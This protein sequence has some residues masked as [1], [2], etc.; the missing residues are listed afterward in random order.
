MSELKDI[1][2]S[3]HLTQQEVAKT[4]GISLRSYVSYE[5]DP[6]K[7]STPKYRFLL[8]E[9]SQMNLLDEEHGTLSV[10]EIR[11]VCSDIFQKYPVEFCY[12]FG[13]YAKGQEKESSDVDLLIS[14]T[15]TGLKF[16]ELTERLRE[17]LRK[18]VDL[19]NLEQL[20]NNETLIKE[21]LKDGIRIYG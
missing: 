13:S 3:R 6:E 9:V 18:K 5:N 14:T 10:D 12:L 19:L 16:F 2:L 17:A 8:Q 4:I 11:T 7:V 1:R 21:V 20:V 15:L